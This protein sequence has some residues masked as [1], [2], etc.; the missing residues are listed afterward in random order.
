VS[1][2][3]SIEE[4]IDEFLSR[5]DG[6]IEKEGRAARRALRRLMPTAF[7]LVYDNYN[8][9]VF[10]FGATEKR[11]DIICS[12]ALYPK[13][14]TLFFMNGKG[15]DDPES[16]LEGSGTTIRGVRLRG[17]AKDLAKPAVKALIGLA[18]ARAEAKTP[19]PSKGRG[20]TIIKSESPKKRRRT[21]A[22]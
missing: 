5:Y 17:G 2:A 7:E 9:L 20:P 11:N 18:I 15:L 1:K 12:I 21:P 6:A 19:L 4:R 22:K 13:W 10:A 16:L 14:V 8:A 3:A